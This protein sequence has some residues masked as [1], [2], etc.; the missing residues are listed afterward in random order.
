VRRRGQVAFTDTLIGSCQ[1][2]PW[3]PSALARIGA[4]LIEPTLRYTP[5]YARN[6]GTQPPAPSFHY[7]SQGTAVAVF[8]LQPAG[9]DSCL[10]VPLLPPPDDGAAVP[11]FRLSCF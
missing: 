4:T 11:G 9:L 10:H 7:P 5:P 6:S 2:Q 3:T 1:A 8:V